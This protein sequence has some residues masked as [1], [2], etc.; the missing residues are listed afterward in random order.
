MKH[1]PVVRIFLLAVLLFL[2]GCNDSASGSAEEKKPTLYTSVVLG[3]CA[4]ASS[5]SSSDIEKMISS[6]IVGY[7]E[8]SAVYLGDCRGC[9]DLTLYALDYC[10]VSADVALDFVD[11]TLFI[12]YVNVQEASKCTCYSSHDFK[13]PSVNYRYVKF[14]EQVFNVVASNI[15]VVCSNK[16]EYKEDY[17]VEKG[18]T[19]L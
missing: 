3:K 15:R 10:D 4:D 11:D 16:G 7:D 8:H 5:S 13:V 14:N 6:L 9:F 17:C 2:V 12:S 18:P 1:L 19:H